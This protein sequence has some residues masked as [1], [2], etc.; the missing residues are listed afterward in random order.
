MRLSAAVLLPFLALAARAAEPS[1]PA[2]DESSSVF[3]TE[4]Q[5][6]FYT[7]GHALARNVSVFGLTPDELKYVTMGLAD[8]VAGKKPLVDLNAYIGKVNDL[9]NT[10][11]AAKTEVQKKKDQAFL[12]KAGKEK[13]AK[14]LSS[15]LIYTEIKKGTGDKPSASDTVKASYTG[16]LADGTVF[17]ASEKHGGPLEFPLNGVIPCWTEGIQR[18]KVGGK[19]KLVCPSAI[20]YGDRGQPPAIPG[21]ATLVFDVEL[22]EI[23]KK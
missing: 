10:R 23:V 7:L 15:G 2:K 9:A 14:T 6:I 8:G 12:K 1:K 19:A 17:D 18:M 11:Q 13:G 22:V 5:K 21:G 4:D 16:T 3:S 20:A